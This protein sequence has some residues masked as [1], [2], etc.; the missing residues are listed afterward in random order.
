MNQRGSLPKMTTE[1]LGCAAAEALCA[2]GAAAQNAWALRLFRL[3]QEDSLQPDVA[4]RSV[5]PDFVG[6]SHFK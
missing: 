3:L 2:C 1:R 4:W 5:G 6:L